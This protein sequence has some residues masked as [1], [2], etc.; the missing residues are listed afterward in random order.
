MDILNFEKWNLKSLYSKPKQTSATAVKK[1][2]MNTTDMNE[3][4]KTM[5]PL[6]SSSKTESWKDPKIHSVHPI[7]FD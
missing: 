2:S 4:I 5:T 3:D 1:E 6:N 7:F